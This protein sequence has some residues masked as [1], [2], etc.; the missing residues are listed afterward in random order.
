MRI[1]LVEDDPML[2]EGLRTALAR[3]CHSLD[4]ETSGEHVNA[5]LRQ[6]QY[7][8]LV[9][10]LG[11]PGKDGMSV[12]KELRSAGESLPVLILTARDAVQD[13]VQGLDAGADDYLL[14]PFDLDE[15]CARIRALGRR[16]ASTAAPALELG[17]LSLIPGSLDVIF[18]GR[19]IT[20]ARREYMLLELL[21][22][23]P[24][25]IFTRQQLEEKL[26]S[27]D[28][29]IGSN[30][31]EVHVHH[32]RKKLGSGIVKTVRGIGY[33]LGVTG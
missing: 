16:Q 28:D 30:A 3:E 24:S 20:L 13:R 25:Q 10:D 18:K 12:L 6:G 9:L 27:L 2:G 17:S 32:L 7:D 11:L 15:L 1:L 33:Q 8:L 5:L 26:Y 23:R 29:D 31:V 4:W 19:S 14:K 22:Q 21:A